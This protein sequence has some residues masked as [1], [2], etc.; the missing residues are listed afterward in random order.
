VLVPQ[1]C[2][3]RPAGR[4]IGYVGT[5]GDSGRMRERQS[6]GG[7]VVV[8]E[9]RVNGRMGAGRQAPAHVPLISDLG[10]Q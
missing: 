9:S 5:V 8:G 4:A 7:A 3:L 6:Q 2:A 10:T 1:H